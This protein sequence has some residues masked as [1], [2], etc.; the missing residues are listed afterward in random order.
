V[1]VMCLVSVSNRI[2]NIV[3]K[4]IYRIPQELMWFKLICE[5]LIKDDKNN[6]FG[7]DKK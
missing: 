1:T 7:L 5:L 4:S 6:I 2:S 3:D